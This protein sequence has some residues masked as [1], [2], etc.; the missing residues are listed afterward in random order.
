MKLLDA[1]S[2]VPGASFSDIAYAALGLPGK[3]V[4]DIFLS[5]MQY[6]FVIA[7]AFFTIINLKNVV[8]GLTGEDIPEYYVGKVLSKN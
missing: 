4:L 1:R 6:G 3:Y 2:K 8:D 7:L 5:V